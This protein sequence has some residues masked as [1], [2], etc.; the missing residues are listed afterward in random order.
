MIAEILDKKGVKM[1]EIL[2]KL[3]LKCLKLLFFMITNRL[4][5]DNIYL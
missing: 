5:V 4:I 3:L 1:L 2:L